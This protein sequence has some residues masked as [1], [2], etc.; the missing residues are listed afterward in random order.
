MSLST[1]LAKNAS[2]QI[3]MNYKFRGQ[4]VSEVLIQRQL[5]YQQNVGW[6]INLSIKS[7]LNTQQ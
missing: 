4:S 3:K 2:K 6:I 5:E 7:T 1:G